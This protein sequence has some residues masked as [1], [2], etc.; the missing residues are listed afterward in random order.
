MQ[1]GAS[2]LC[3]LP[4][5]THTST[6]YPASNHMP[7]FG[8]IRTSTWLKG[9]FCDDMK[10]INSLILWHTFNLLG[11]MFLLE[12][13]YAYMRKDVFSKSFIF[14]KIS[15][16]RLKYNQ[17]FFRNL[18]MLTFNLLDI[19]LTSIVSTYCFFLMENEVE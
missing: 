9:S 13:Y 3:W 8:M 15:S 10:P 11:I 2:M 6:P 5:K 4:T 12:L 14:W 18:G 19:I 1:F 17:S 16:E 7:L